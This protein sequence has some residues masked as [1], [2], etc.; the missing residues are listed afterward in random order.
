MEDKR[1]SGTV[2]SRIITLIGLGHEK[3]HIYY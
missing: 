2:V 3:A 1:D